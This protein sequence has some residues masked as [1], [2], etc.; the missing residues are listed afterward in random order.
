LFV[1]GLLG[2]KNA[3]FKP[4]PANLKPLLPLSVFFGV[5]KK[6]EILRRGRRNLSEVLCE[7]LYVFSILPL[8][9]ILVNKMFSRFSNVPLFENHPHST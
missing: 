8:L 9:L 2:L 3:V 7:K 5:A 1:F 4:Q 6:S